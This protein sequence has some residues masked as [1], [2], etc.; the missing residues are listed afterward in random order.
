[1]SWKRRGV[2]RFGVLVVVATVLAAMVA[3]GAV[4]GVTAAGQQ[5]VRVVTGTA[6]CS[7]MYCFSPSQTVATTG[8]TLT[9]S[10]T[11][12]APH[13]VTRCS[14]A[15]CAGRGPG[16]GT[17]S[18]DGSIAADNG[19]YSHTFTAAGT[20]FYFCSFHGYAVMHGSITVQAPATTPTPRPVATARPTPSHVMVHATPRPIPARPPTATA[21]PAVAATPA[22]AASPALAITIPSESASPSS[23][24]SS[25]AATP[26]SG[27]AQS[28]PAVPIIAVL[29]VVA[30]L[31]GATYVM[32]R[33]RSTA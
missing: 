18:L 13:T 33:R 29:L 2:H 3:G 5:S 8:D 25:T 7:S 21:A 15:D 12:T 26:L 23:V 4:L 19:S 16:T 9:F 10:N 6:S 31:G 22:T 28:S 27:S 30:A 32:R 17:D 20:Y 24:A 11:T 1:M 14:A